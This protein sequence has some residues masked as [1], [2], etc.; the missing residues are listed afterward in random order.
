MDFMCVLQKKLDKVDIC[1]IR[2]Q[3]C[4]MSYNGSGSSAYMPPPQFADGQVSECSDTFSMAGATGHMG[5]MPMGISTLPRRC[6]Q[7]LGGGGSDTQPLIIG[8]SFRTLPR[9]PPADSA[10]PFAD[11]GV[12]SAAAV[13][14]YPPSSAEMKSGT[15]TLPLKSSLKKTSSSST[16]AAASNSRADRQEPNLAGR[17]T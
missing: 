17:Y 3:S 16:A 14:H 6:H 5:V 12:Q 4:R 2:R 8:T 7:T 10:N 15:Q 1:L 11:G 9:Q 13:G